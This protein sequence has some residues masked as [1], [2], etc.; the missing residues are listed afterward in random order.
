MYKQYS[1]RIH[2]NT[3]SW[4]CRFVRPFGLREEVSQ[5]NLTLRTYLISRGPTRKRKIDGSFSLSC[6]TNSYFACIK[7]AFKEALR[8]LCPLNQPPQRFARG[9]KF[10]QGYL[11]VKWVCMCLR[12]TIENFCTALT[13]LHI[14]GALDATVIYLCF[15]DI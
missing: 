4:S 5:E 12:D 15:L 11:I 9:S 7:L 10:G 13:A 8:C 1:Q 3:S 6:E 2:G 14:H